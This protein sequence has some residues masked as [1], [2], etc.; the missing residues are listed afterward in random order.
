MPLSLLSPS[1]KS[2]LTW[3]S[4]LGLHGISSPEGVVNGEM[5]SS[6]LEASC[7][8]E[9]GSEHRWSKSGY[10]GLKGYRSIFQA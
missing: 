8:D 1:H 6:K 10:G 3:S 4:P 9:N 7:Q 2:P 5:G